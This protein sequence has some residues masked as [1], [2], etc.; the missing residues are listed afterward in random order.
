MSQH[1]PAGVQQVK[2]AQWFWV[3]EGQGRGRKPGAQ[4]SSC[5]HSFHEGFSPGQHWPAVLQRTAPALGSINFQ[6]PRVTLA[7]KETLRGRGLR[8]GGSLRPHRLCRG[9]GVGAGGG[10]TARGESGPGQARP[11]TSELTP[12]EGSP[13][14][15]LLFDFAV[16]PQSSNPSHLEQLGSQPSCSREKKTQLSGKTLIPG[17]PTTLSC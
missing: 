1:S 2:R 8:L 10:P 11:R 7:W 3:T 5:S 14:R 6:V 16:T 4:P 12:A 15:V 13:G 17:D 9:G